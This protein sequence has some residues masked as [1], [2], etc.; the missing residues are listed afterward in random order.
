[1]AD[2]FDEGYF[3]D[4]QPFSVNDGEGIHTNIFLAGCPLKC[5]WCA[6][7]ESQS[8]FNRISYDTR[9]CTNCNLCAKECPNGISTKLN[10]DSARKSCIECKKCVLVCP[11]G[12]KRTLV[13]KRTLSD[14]AEEVYK[15]NIFFRYSGGGVT[16]S[17]GEP[18]YQIDV[19]KKLTNKFYDDG[20]SLSIETSG[21][22]NWDTA[23]YILSKMDLIFVDIKVMDNKKHKY[24]TGKENTR[25][26]ENIKKIS[27]LGINTVVRIPLIKGVNSDIE[28]ITQTSRFVGEVFE[29]PKIE[30][31]PYHRFGEGKYE[32]LFL[33][34][35]P[36]YFARPT[37]KEIKD[38]EKI[39]ESYGIEIVSYK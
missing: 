4:I 6:N 35:P 33:K 24:F 21:Y 26:L 20:I 15:H 13:N 31:L 39:I 10:T 37:E 19:L 1:M 14:I 38:I 36:K 17:G 34:K 16:F 11:T 28:N 7:P 30:I 2:N 32:A 3:M 29:N 22:W 18:F 27:K 23:K 12:A 8:D 25:I 9:I 5:L